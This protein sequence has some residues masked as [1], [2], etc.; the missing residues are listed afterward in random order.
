MW[1]EEAR[2]GAPGY[3]TK[4]PR[5]RLRFGQIPIEEDWIRQ[6]D[7]EK[8]EKLIRR[9]YISE[10]ICRTMVPRFPVP[11]GED[12]IR[13]VWDLS[14]NGL[15]ET[16]YTPSFF[17]ATMA[18]YLRQIDV[19]FF[20][21]DFDV[22]EQFHNCPL[23]ESEQLYC[24]VEIPE[25]LR[26]KFNHEGTAIPKYLCWNRLV[27]GWQSSPY[28][29]LRMFARVI[30]LAKGTPNDL[31]SAFIWDRV[32]LNLPGSPNYNPAQPQVMRVKTNGSLA[33]DIVTFYDDGR[34]F[35]ATEEDA[36][37]ALRQI[38]SRIQ[39]YGNQ[40]AARK[41]RAVSQRPGAWAGGV[42]YTDQKLLR[43]FISQ[44]KWDKTRAFLSWVA[45][46]LRNN[47]GLMDRIKFCSGKGFLVHVSLCY[48]FM[49][50]YMKGF[51]LSENSWRENR[52]AEGW[53]I[54]FPIEIECDTQLGMEEP[55][56]DETWFSLMDHHEFGNF[57]SDK[58]PPTWVKAVPRLWEDIR[59][60]QLFFDPP[61]PLQVIVCPVEGAS[62]V[63]YGGGDASGEGFGGQMSPL[64]LKPLLRRG[65]W[66]ASDSENSSNWRELRN[67][68]EL[69]RGE[70]Q[71]GRLAGR[72]VWLATDNSTA[73]NA[74][75]R[76]TS[77]SKILHEMITEL[78]LLTL[79]GNFIL[80]IFHIP[81]TRMIQ[82]GIDA[83]SRG[84]LN[85]SA[86]EDSIQTLLPLHISPV[87]RS[88][89]LVEWLKS[90][91]DSDFRSV[92]QK[93]GFMEPNNAVNIC[94]PP[95]QR[96]GSGIYHPPQLF[97]LLKNLHLAN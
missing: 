24:G 13:V 32:I 94:T 4:T 75:Y 78:R 74:Y 84:E 37:L 9:R 47:N 33:A 68:V 27:F 60:L 34:V 6:K 39:Y 93:I 29:A 76:G 12:D 1:R 35:V 54:D 28:L 15:N 18:T 8:L 52:D 97:T 51:H 16:M 22:G 56:D 91:L 42:A 59:I 71:R 73:A 62:F 50:P 31:N 89:S 66:C 55:D 26:H 48:D 82:S 72:E 79:E 30:E 95:S 49:N 96:R 90:W 10:G 19:G 63:A 85:I 23:H 58:A 70:V 14:K 77:T 11:K 92:N 87:Q 81:G 38:T 2:D 44:E 7:L 45:E 21:G 25:E 3:H 64:G 36:I 83:L 69:I 57:K 5:P 17:L 80:H 43:K 67:L 41:R 40:D 46:N 53:K 65:F 88:P 86:L 20:G 61:T